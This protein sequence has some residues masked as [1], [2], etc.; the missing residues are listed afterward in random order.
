MDSYEYRESR[1]S[2]TGV[3]FWT[4]NGKSFPEDRW[5]DF[6]LVLANWWLNSVKILRS[7]KGTRFDFMDGPF[8][9][10]CKHVRGLV[11]CEFLDTRRERQ[12]DGEWVGSLKE[13]SDAILEYAKAVLLF[14]TQS[15][16]SNKDVK[17]LQRDLE[18]FEN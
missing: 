12:I 5:N 1:D 8:R 6:V 17:S 18:A 9:I 7:G 3:V 11:Y 15:G 16:L 2:L 14:C 10:N 13:I 4:F